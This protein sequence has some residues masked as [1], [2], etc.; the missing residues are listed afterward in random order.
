MTF[1]VF[2]IISGFLHSPQTVVAV[3]QS[4]LNRNSDQ[5]FNFGNFK[6]DFFQH[7]SVT[8]NNSLLLKEE[9]ECPFKCITRPH[10]ISFNVAVYP[11]SNDLYLC[12][13][14]DADKYGAKNKLQENASFHHYSPSWVSLP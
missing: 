6:V 7:L 12:E 2:L 14:L 13:L 11:D 9:L 8:V 4:S 5:R 3:Q 10:C 1:S